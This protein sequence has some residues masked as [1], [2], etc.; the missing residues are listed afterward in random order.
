M[1]FR[2]GFADVAIQSRLPRADMGAVLA[3]IPSSPMLTTEEFESISRYYS[4]LAPDSLTVPQSASK[5]LEGF[6]L[7]DV[8]TLQG[9]LVTALK[10]DRRKNNLFIG[11][12]RGMLF[13]LNQDF[14]VNDS[15]QLRSAVSEIKIG[16]DK[17]LVSTMGVMD[18]SE[19]AKGDILQ[20][21][22]LLEV[23]AM[24]TDS[25]QR[26]VFFET[27][28]LNADDI[29]DLVVC[30]FGNYTGNLLILEGLQDGEYKKHYLS[31]LSGA[32]KIVIDDLNNDGANDMLVLM[33]QGDERIMVYYNEGDFRFREH[34]VL[35]FPPVYGLS[36]MTVIDFNGDGFSDIVT[37]NGDNADYSVLH[38]PYHAVRLFENNK[39]NS[40]QEVWSHPMPGASQCKAADFDLDGDIDIAAISF[41]PKKGTDQD[42]GFL[43]FENLGNY[44]FQS[45]AI[46][47]TKLGRWLVMESADVD[48]DSDIDIILGG[49]NYNGLGAK[50]L[51][52]ARY[53][54]KDNSSLLILQ[55]EKKSRR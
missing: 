5:P 1:A 6:R 18:P 34:T 47:G 21:N 13:K 10:Q 11:V 14:T 42:G 41:F 8:P 53:N 49:F 16:R 37:T 36:D 51:K 40:F 55:N 46:S 25:L 2:M 52:M 33:A 24:I 54:A 15:L 20:L 45:R 27:G 9:E 32:R 30:N 23:N 31:R 26:P 28:D 12:R 50:E 43:L 48:G 39:R 44:Q 4:R 7:I 22:A 19:Q 35:R 38:K 3:A 29:E 17:I